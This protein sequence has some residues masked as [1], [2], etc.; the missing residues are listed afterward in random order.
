M[1]DHLNCRE[2]SIVHNVLMHM[3]TAL[4]VFSAILAIVSQMDRFE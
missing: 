2:W 1:R 3:N 4:K